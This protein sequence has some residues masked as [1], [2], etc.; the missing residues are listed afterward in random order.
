MGDIGHEPQYDELYYQYIRALWSV[1]QLHYGAGCLLLL[2]FILS[3]RVCKVKEKL[4]LTPQNT[5]FDKENSL[6]GP[7]QGRVRSVNALFF[8]T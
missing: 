4:L 1:N 5:F 6:L 7:F 3:A 8:Y 2:N